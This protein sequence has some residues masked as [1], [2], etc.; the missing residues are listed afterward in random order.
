VGIGRGSE[1]FPLPDRAASY[2]VI[3]APGVHVNTAQAY[4]DLSPRLTSES[5]Q[6]KIFSFQT[7]T[8]DPGH[9]A[10]GNDFEPVVFQ[11]HPALASLKKRLMRAGASAAMMTGSGSAVF[12]LFGTREDAARAAGKLGK[13]SAFPISLVSRVRYREMWRRALEEHATG[14]LWP[15]Q[16]RYAR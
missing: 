1:L 15:P 6:N 5:Q 4:R 3:V 9:E 7:Q 11:Q 2:G 12:G 16:S 14:S 10:A 8:W 13:A